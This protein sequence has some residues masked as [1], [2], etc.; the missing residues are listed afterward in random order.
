VTKEQDMNPEI[1]IGLT[2][3]NSAGTLRDALRSIFAQ[4]LR[5]WEL[6]IIDD[7]STDGSFDI[8]RSVSDPR[9]KVYREDTRLGFVNALNRMTELATANYYARMD[10]DDMMHPE[11]LSRQLE[12]LKTN[13]DIDVVDTAMCSINQEGRPIGIREVKSLDSRPMVLL[14]GNFFHHATIMGRTEWFQK[15]RYDPFFIRA[16]D[17][18]LW[19]RTFKTSRFDRIKEPLYFVREGRV[20]IRNY[21]L[22]C[23]T[24]RCIIKTYG[25]SLVGKQATLQLIAESYIKGFTYRIFALFDSHNTLV[26]MRN[27]KLNSD[28]KIYADSIIEHIKSTSVPGL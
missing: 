2:F 5:D 16:E 1:T 13:P 11:R 8:A 12:Y 23:Q 28:E 4:T 7:H 18:E 24:V 21:L 9:V 22:S 25:P 20:N 10:S 6:I 19:C 26:N 14:R 27:R 15:N 17:C 3:Y